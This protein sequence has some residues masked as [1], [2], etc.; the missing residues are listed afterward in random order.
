MKKLITLIFP[1]F[2]I[3]LTT[4]A[5][6]TQ[7]DIE[8][9]NGVDINGNPDSLGVTCELRGLV[10]CMDFRGGMGL[11]F[12]II[13]GSNTAGIRI[14]TFA[15]LNSYVVTEG[16][17]L[18]VF[19]TVSQYNGFLQFSPD[20]IAFI[21]SGNTLS[22]PALVSSLDESTENRLISLHNVHLVDSTEWIGIG[23]IFN[24]LVTDGGIDTTTLWIDKDVSLF[25][26]PAPAGSFNVVGF[27]I[28]Y[29]ASPPYTEHY[30]L[31]VC[32]ISSLVSIS[33]SACGSYTSPSGNHVWTSSNIY[34]DTINNL[35]DYDTIITVNLTINGPNISVTQSGAMLTSD[36][37]GA[38]YQWL[39]CLD[40]AP[41]AG[42]TNQS[43]TAST[44]GDYAV[45][46]NN[47]GCID[48]S[49]CYTVTGTTGI[50]ENDFGNELH[51]YPNPTD[52][53]FSIDLADS[54]SAV[55]ITISDLNGKL[56]QSKIFNESQLLNLNLTEPAGIYLLRIESDTKNT[57][58]PLMKK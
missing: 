34:V 51:L 28:Q 57:V 21:S 56:L 12:G 40:W 29:D 5:Q 6:Y 35:N 2:L 52:G 55:T 7:Y 41:I 36:E 47:N 50:I 44:N 42:E 20:S 25:N 3:V 18:H 33:D 22:A 26:F 30:R 16:D 13:N 19:G 24:V 32:N 27:G 39:N 9:I 43:F 54:Y 15:D 49:T 45:I 23:S 48:T 37:S 58:I 10:G 4:H 11:D 14:F 31:S 53:N 1:A 17:S 46:I 8:D 38:T